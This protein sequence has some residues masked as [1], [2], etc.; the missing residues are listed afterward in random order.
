MVGSSAQSEEQQFSAVDLKRYTSYPLGHFSIWRFYFQLAVVWLFVRPMILYKCRPKIYGKENI[1]DQGPFIVA[2]NHISMLDPPLIAYAVH[3]PI[4]FMAKK[5]LFKNKLAAEFYRSQ[6]CFALDRK[7]PDKATLKTALNVLNSPAKWALGMFPEGTRSTTGTILP[8][9]KGIGALAK[10]TNAPI[11]PI[12]LHKDSS[13]RFIV[14]I[15]TLISH[16]ADEEALQDM[17]YQAFVTLSKP[18]SR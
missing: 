13:G 9:K 18:V 1:P 14:R 7:N 3:Y 2:S 17:L 10:K 16:W 5:E 15:G 4:A 6:G 8:L 12:G 11:L